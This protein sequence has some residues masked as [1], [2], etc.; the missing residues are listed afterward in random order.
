ML[1]D[2]SKSALGCALHVGTV[3]GMGY[4]RLLVRSWQKTNAPTTA[5]NAL[6]KCVSSRGL[7][8]AKVTQKMNLTRHRAD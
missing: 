2:L 1:I 5:Y 7:A 3:I 6:S 4:G 8:S